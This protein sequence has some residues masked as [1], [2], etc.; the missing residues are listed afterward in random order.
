MQSNNESVGENFYPRFTLAQWLKKQSMMTMISDRSCSQTHSIWPLS[1]LSRA[2][3]EA[4]AQTQTI[5][6][7]LVFDVSVEIS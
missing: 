6:P 5:V 2:I 4:L 7:L 1:S 3:F